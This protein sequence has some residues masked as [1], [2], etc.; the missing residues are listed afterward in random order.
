M[1]GLESKPYEEWLRELGLFSLEKRRL[2][3]DLT[4]FYDCLK[5]GCS[6]MGASLFSSEMGNPV[7]K[8]KNREVKTQSN[9]GELQFERLTRELEAERQIVASQLE[10]CKLGSE[11]GSMSS[12]R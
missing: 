4:A 5:G 2:R 8:D 6:Q 12:I 10:R 11:T 1:E 9:Y 3:G 7:K